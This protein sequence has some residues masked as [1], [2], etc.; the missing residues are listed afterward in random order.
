MRLVIFSLFFAFS[1]LFEACVDHP[2]IPE[3]KFVNIY[4]QLQL[5][6]IQYGQHY[7]VH[8]EKIDSLLRSYNVSKEEVKSTLDWYNRSPER[9]KTFFAKVESKIGT[10]SKNSFVIPR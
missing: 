4:V 5:L 10:K 9:W 7:A 8:H 2:P 6:D 1:M 3:E